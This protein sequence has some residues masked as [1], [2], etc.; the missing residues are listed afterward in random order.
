M[1]SS[2]GLKE[3]PLISMRRRVERFWGRNENNVVDG[4]LRIT[5]RV[6]EVSLG[7]A[8]TI[9]EVG[10]AIIREIG[11]DVIVSPDGDGRVWVA[12]RVGIDRGASHEMNASGVMN[13][14]TG[15]IE[16]IDP[17]TLI[18]DGESAGLSEFARILDLSEEQLGLLVCNA[19]NADR[20]FDAL[21][22]AREIPPKVLD[23]LTQNCRESEVMSIG[24]EIVDFDRTQ[25][26]GITRLLSALPPRYGF[27]LIEGTCNIGGSPSNPLRYSMDS[28]EYHPIAAGMDTGTVNYP[29]VKGHG[30][31]SRTVGSLDRVDMDPF[32]MSDVDRLQA[33]LQEG[34]HPLHPL[35]YKQY[36]DEGILDDNHEVVS[37]PSVVMM[38]KRSVYPLDGSRY[39][40]TSLPVRITTRE[41]SIYWSEA[42]NAVENSRVVTELAKQGVLP[43]RTGI[44]RDVYAGQLNE[45]PRSTYEVRGGLID[46]AYNV[47]SDSLDD[48]PPAS[49]IPIASSA[50][51]SDNL[52]RPGTTLLEDLVESG[53]DP[54]QFYRDATRLSIHNQLDLMRVGWTPEAHSQNQMYLFDLN[55]MNLWGIFIRDSEGAKVDSE[56]IAKYGIQY[57]GILNTEEYAGS[58]LPVDNDPLRRKLITAYMHH[59]TFD[60]NVGVLGH[61]VSQVYGLPIEEV[62]GI[63]R[64]TYIEWWEKNRMNYLDYADLIAPGFHRNNLFT[65]GLKLSAGAPSRVMDSHPLIPS[66][67]EM[68]EILG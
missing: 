57:N 52:L 48:V 64:E 51:W 58:P 28:V 1:F 34:Y 5:P 9:S 29:L 31:E 20:L 26:G 63:S 39:M 22:R 11:E 38:S 49:G 53:L 66:H 18:I 24:Q 12:A 46:V 32:A 41:R 60:H 27:A 19:E 54:I 21:H 65:R 35:V 25:P 45:D 23:E 44:M 47:K 10:G 33:L 17:D 42:Q 55:E 50:L 56:R 16:V 61:Y 13:E 62:Q 43:S 15:E 36:L 67:E 59:G 37:L 3:Y 4:D 2:V 30:L 7:L 6:G 8:T 68:R 14:L 40:K